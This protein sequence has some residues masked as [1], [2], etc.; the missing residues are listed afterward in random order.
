M[1][2]VDEYRQPEAAQAI[3]AAIASQAAPQ[4][5]YR[6]MEFCGGHTHAIFRYGLRQLLPANVEFVHGPGC[7]VCVLPGGRLESLLRLL[8]QRDIILCSYGDMLR[9]PAAQGRSLQRLKARGADVRMVYSTQ[10][11]LQ[12]ARQNPQ[13]EVVFFAIGFE[14]TT[15]A[16]AVALIAARD[17]GLKNFSVYCNHVLTP[18]AMAAILSTEGDTTGSAAIA[19][20]ALLGPSHVSAIIGSNAYAPLAQ[21][22][23]KPIVIAGFEPLDLLQS[24]LMVIEQINAGRHEIENEYRRAVSGEGNARAQA[25]MAE[26]FTLRDEFEWRGL[27]V[28]PHSAL[29][30]HAAY[31]QFDAEQ[32]FAMERVPLADN[33]GCDCAEVLRGRRR[34]EE[35]KLF[36]KV[37]T[38]DNPMGACMVS[39]EG[40]CAA[41]WHYGGR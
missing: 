24:T 38:P 4:R 27:G 36:A 3:A 23:R 31:A 22:Y 19:I 12:L 37:C 7:P 2:Y 13:R 18:P 8:E 16:T 6:I 11:A 5:H 14:T 21:R 32:R 33:K 1:K 30:I 26:V 15:P 41:V 29:A 28:L 17:E 35:C 25:V 40:A 20:D 39:A 9:V 34:P 10:D